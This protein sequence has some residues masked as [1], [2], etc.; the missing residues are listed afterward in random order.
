MPSLPA[1][2]RLSYYRLHNSKQLDKKLDTLFE[3]L[4][5]E[6]P[7]SLDDEPRST[8]VAHIFHHVLTLGCQS[9]IIQR[10]VQD[11]DF[12]SE[13]HAYYG[14]LY[15]HVDRYCK[16]IHCFSKAWKKSSDPLD[17]IDSAANSD[18]L[19]F[20]TLRPITFCPIAASI[21]RPPSNTP[22]FLLSRDSFDVHLA[23]KTF[24]VVGTPFMQQDNAVG[25]CAQASIWMAL[26]TLRRKEGLAAHSP[27]EITTSATRYVVRGRTLPNREGLQID[28]M[29][30]AIRSSGY[31]PNLLWFRD[32]GDPL[33]DPLHVRRLLYPYIESGIPVILA[34]FPKDK[35]QS[36]HAVVLIGHGWDANPADK[37]RTSVRVISKGFVFLNSA[38][39]AAPFY[40]H[41]DNTGPYLPIPSTATVDQPYSL[42]AVCYAIP[43]LPTE[44]CLTAEEAEQTAL[45]SLLRLMNVSENDSDEIQESLDHFLIRTYLQERNVFRNMVLES[46]MHDEVKKYY[47]YK[48]MP[49][50]IWITELNLLKDYECGDKPDEAVRVGEI[51]VDPTADIQQ[52]GY[53]TIHVPNLIVDRD[54]HE[55]TIRFLTIEGDNQYSPIY[56]E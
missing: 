16:R 38:T 25:A 31:S 32:V 27:A 39:W 26:R 3:M 37:I 21:L 4:N 2:N 55:Q 41:N 48:E 43:L 30:E 56:R 34:I 46:G 50:R 9:V 54:P 51:I 1:S 35:S 23:G 7:L 12:T 47:R 42:D 13:Y 49:R 29:M 53:L 5:A 52:A 28:Q 45:I 17:V 15:G 6:L 18:Y 24:S 14:K 8:P 20:I 44:V 11:P 19:G 22:F 10:S 40:M 33:S 36:G